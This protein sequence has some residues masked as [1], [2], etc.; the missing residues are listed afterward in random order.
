MNDEQ[1]AT[2]MSDA[3]VEIVRQLER[4]G[5]ALQ[6][7]C[8][9]PPYRVDTYLVDCHA[10]LEVDGPRH[11]VKA[12]RERDAYLEC[13]YGLPTFRLRVNEIKLVD[14]WWPRLMS[15]I[16]ELC[17]TADERR[18]RVEMKTPWL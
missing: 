12:D 11:G 15:F 14:E 5:V 4:R 6:E 16:L 10:A 9:F 7:E 8:D 13:V 3:H 2:V 18:E 17:E 1:P